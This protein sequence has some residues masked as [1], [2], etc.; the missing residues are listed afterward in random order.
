MQ[1]SYVRR[2]IVLAVS[3]VA[4]AT[5]LLMLTTAALAGRGPVNSQQAPAA[6]VGRA[7]PAG[8]T[9]HFGW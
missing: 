1:Q 3:V 4:I 9:E 7:H 2:I 5:L 8:F 6:K